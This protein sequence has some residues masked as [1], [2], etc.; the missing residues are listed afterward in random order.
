LRKF[1]TTLEFGGCCARGRARSE[2]P[3]SD[4]ENTP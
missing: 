1:S 4:F 2:T 3:E